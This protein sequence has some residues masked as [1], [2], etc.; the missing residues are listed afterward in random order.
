MSKFYE[1][2]VTKREIVLVE[3]PDGEDLSEDEI[4]D[5]ASY[6]VSDE[7]RIESLTIRELKSDLEIKS[8][9]D[10]CDEKALIED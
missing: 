10:T 7:D 6:E 2:T 3:M 1:V 4:V 5:I 9:L 8:C